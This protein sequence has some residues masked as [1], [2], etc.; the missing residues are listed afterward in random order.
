LNS[1]GGLQVLRDWFEVLKVEDHLFATAKMTA[2]KS[3]ITAK[4]R[5][6]DYKLELGQWLREVRSQWV[7]A[8]TQLQ[9]DKFRYLSP[10]DI[11]MVL[12]DEGFEQVRLKEDGCSVRVWRHPDWKRDHRNAGMKVWS[13]SAARDS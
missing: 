4:D 7:F 11:A 6:G 9:A 2:S 5:S 13:A 8:T 10:I 1:E 12:K 3:E